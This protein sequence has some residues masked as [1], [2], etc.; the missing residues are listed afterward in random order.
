MNCEK[1]QD[2]LELRTDPK[3]G[4]LSPLEPIIKIP[5]LI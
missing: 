2:L 4:S 5:F 1:T 3:T